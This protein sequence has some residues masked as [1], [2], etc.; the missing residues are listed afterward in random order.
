MTRVFCSIYKSSKKDEMYLYVL[1]ANGL[2]SVPESLLSVFGKPRHVSDLLLDAERK[3]A[4]ADVKQVLEM[5]ATQGF[6]LQM[7]PPPETWTLTPDNAPAW[8]R[9]T[10]AEREEMK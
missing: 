8:R 1:K 7:P 10:Q 9:R 3:L 5:I 6:Y 4:R 2:K